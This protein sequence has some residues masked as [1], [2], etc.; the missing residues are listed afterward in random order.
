MIYWFLGNYVYS[1]GNILVYSIRKMIY[2]A[3][4]CIYNE[5]MRLNRVVCDARRKV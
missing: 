5:N 4:F 2:F 3:Y 1:Y